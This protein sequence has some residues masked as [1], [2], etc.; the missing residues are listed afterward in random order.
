MQRMLNSLKYKEGCKELE[1]LDEM[2]KSYLQG[3]KSLYLSRFS[4][5]RLLDASNIFYWEPTHKTH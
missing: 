1:H 2:Y 4:T 5:V 3:F